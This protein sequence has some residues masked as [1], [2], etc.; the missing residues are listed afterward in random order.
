MDKDTKINEMEIT[1]EFIMVGPDVKGEIV[2]QNLNDLDESGV[3]LITKDGEKVVGFIT[4]R[5]MIEALASGINPLEKPANEMMNTDFMEVNGEETL[6]NLLGKISE[7]YPKV[8]AVTDSEG[9][10]IGY[11]SKNDYKDAMMVLGYYDKSSEPKT[12]EEW[13]ARGIAMT[14]LGRVEDALKCY[15]NSLALHID[16]ERAWFDLGKS[17]EADKRLKDA[18]LC[19]DRVVTLN[20]ENE[21]AWMNRGNVYSILRMPDRAVQSYSR[22]TKLNPENDESLMKIGLAYCDLG[23]TEKA[24]TFLD[25]AAQKTGETAELW[26]WKGNA[27]KKAKK[28]EE[29]IDCF[30]NAIKL[31]IMNEDAWFNK[32][33]SLHILGENQRAIECLEQV[34]KIN[35]FNESAREAL[36]IVIGN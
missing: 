32:G 30:N 8:I 4:W 1:D 36:Q 25:S 14:A 34:L 3:V 16:K 9:Y 27:Y 22:A 21:E 23:D 31:D 24:I 17:F 10:C 7:E 11:F 33:V 19:Y 26:Y 28:H 20:T 5:E 2:A 18:I 35:P 12:P 15:E 6:G 13:R 29:A